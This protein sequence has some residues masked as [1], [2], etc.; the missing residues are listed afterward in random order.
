[1][2]YLH[3]QGTSG[4]VVQR[5]GRSNC[6]NAGEPQHL[7]IVGELL[8]DLRDFRQGLEEGVDDLRVEM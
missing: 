3:V 1:M 5:D 4:A 8:A 2:V 6:G 7:V